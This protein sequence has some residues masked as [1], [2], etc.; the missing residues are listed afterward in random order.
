MEVTQ[1]IIGLIFSLIIGSFVTAL[2]LYTL[3]GLMGLGDKPKPEVKRV[4]PYVTGIV[5]RLVFTILIGLDIQGIPQAM[6]GWLALKFATNWN[7]DLWKKDP[8]TRSFA[9]TALLA[10]LISMLMAVLGGFICKGSLWST[11]ISNFYCN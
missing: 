11:L 10:G 6:I 7:S 8:K 2:F 1:W 4:P 3:R 9:F 5:E